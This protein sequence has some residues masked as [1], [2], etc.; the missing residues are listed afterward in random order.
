MVTGQPYMVIRYG[1]KQVR[2]NIHVWEPVNAFWHFAQSPGSGAVYNIG[3][4]RHANCSMAEAIAVCERLTGRPMNGLS[5]TRPGR[6]IISDGFRTLG[7][8]N[9]TTRG[10]G[11]ATISNQFW[12]R[13]STDKH[14][15]LDPYDICQLS[16]FAG[17]VIP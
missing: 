9:L 1:G 17:D 13:L 12:P 15:D 14:G 3:G 2:D 7:G 4:G 16:A 5:P 8:S 6:A 10:G 11:I